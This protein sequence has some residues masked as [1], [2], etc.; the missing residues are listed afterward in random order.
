MTQLERARTAG[1]DPE[2][3]A[4]VPLPN[5]A[6]Q[7]LLALAPGRSHGYA[8]AKEVEENT[9]GRTRVGTGSL[10]LSL[11][12]LCDQGLIETCDAAAGG[13]RR[14]KHYRMTDLGRRVAAAESRRLLDLVSLAR[15]RELVGPADWLDLPEP[16]RGAG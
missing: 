9:G 1:L 8:I 2:A 15:R 6:F 5:L 14:R 12:K 11:S 7:T 10:Y 4:F 3:E 13:D 16:E